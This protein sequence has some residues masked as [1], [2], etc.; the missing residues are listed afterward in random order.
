MSSMNEEILKLVEK[1]INR[2]TGIASGFS[3]IKN[4][5]DI[6]NLPYYIAYTCNISF[7]TDGWESSS[8][9]NGAGAS[10]DEI[11]AKVKAICESMERYSQAIYKEEKLLSASYEKIKR[12][13]LDP[14][15]IVS[16]SKKQLKK[17]KNEKGMKF[18]FDKETIFKWVKG[19]NLTLNKSIFIPAQLVYCNYKL[20]EEPVINIPLS[21]GASLGLSL[22]EAICKGIYEVVERDAFMINYLNR[23]PREKITLEKIENEEMQKFIQ[24]FKEYEL[25][26]KVYDI[27]TDIPIYSFVCIMVDN[28]LNCFSIGL[29]TSLNPIG[30]IIGAIEEA[31]Q[32]TYNMRNFMEKT[33]KK[34]MMW[35]RK[36]PEDISTFSDRAISW[37]GKEQMK[38]LDFWTK[39]KEVKDGSKLKNLSSGNWE[40]DL[41]FLIKILSEKKM[42]VIYADVTT[43]DIKEL[44]F[45]VVKVIIPGMQPLYLQEK[46]KYLGGERLYEVPHMLGYKKRMVKENELN[47]I[48]HP[49]L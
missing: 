44:G 39:S 12:T 7:F 8:G 48:P 20:R 36:H 30:G 43:P 45:S 28:K 18:D 24:L 19:F 49:F 27:T 1:I 14:R 35:L 6:P 16:F 26:L 31:F 2:K 5:P 13:A 15:K 10:F 33:D 47:P 41:K 40:K 25:Q 34:R 11:K 21:T 4:Y 22:E 38:N 32:G 37:L 46:Y 9:L 23:L 3:Q 17:L 29:K 42:D